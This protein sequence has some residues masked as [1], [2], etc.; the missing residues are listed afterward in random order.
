MDKKIF[1]FASSLLI[2]FFIG[3]NLSQN[4]KT[5]A[6]V[7]K[8]IS[9]QIIIPVKAHIIKDTS[10]AYTSSRSEE[11]VISLLEKANQIWVKADIYFQLEEI[12][13]TNVSF[14]AIPNAI[15]G[16]YLELTGHENFAGDK[17]NFFLVQSLNNINGLSLTSINS[18]LVADYTTVND[19]RTTAHELGHILDLR[20]VSPSNRLM[21]RG[22]NGELLSP[23]EVLIARKSAERLLR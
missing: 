4:T 22:R 6:E 15:N 19:F 5:N 10:E 11:N 8:E 12:V 16:N 1:I 18:V 14:E 2:I 20:H 13:V 17:I 7:T 21:A 23:E 9:E 3:I